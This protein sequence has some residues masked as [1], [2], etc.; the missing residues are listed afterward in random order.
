MDYADWKLGAPQMAPGIA[1]EM[2]QSKAFV[3]PSPEALAKALQGSYWK[4]T[5]EGAQY[6]PSVTV[7]DKVPPAYENLGG[8][9]V[10]DKEKRMCQIMLL[11]NS[12][13]DRGCIEQHER[14]HVAGLDH[15]DHPRGFICP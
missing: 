4:R 3:P 5:W 14:M 1:Q 2:A 8:Y 13:M 6:E 9:T 15:P 11:R 7:V 12:P 10:C